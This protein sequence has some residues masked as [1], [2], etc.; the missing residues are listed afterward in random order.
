[1]VQL[2][3]GK[4]AAGT[5]DGSVSAAAQYGSFGAYGPVGLRASCD[6]IQVFVTLFFPTRSRVGKQAVGSG[7]ED[8]VLLRRDKSSGRK[9]HAGG[10][11]G[12]GGVFDLEC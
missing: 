8:R 9:I 7:G 2:S 1:M 6:G 3:F 4:E 5:A 11:G 10:I 12:R